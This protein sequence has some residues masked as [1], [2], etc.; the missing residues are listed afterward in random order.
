MSLF[1]INYTIIQDCPAFQ[2]YLPV[3]SKKHVKDQ[4]VSDK[5]K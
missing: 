1:F 3:L 5:W 4:L 2:G